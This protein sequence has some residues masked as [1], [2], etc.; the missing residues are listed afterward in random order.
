MADNTVR[1]RFVWH[2]LMTPNGTGAHEFY[3]KTVGWTTEPWKQ[4]PSYTMFA[5]PTGPLGASVETRTG[6]PE[7]IPYVGTPDVDATAEAVTRL[8]GK[9]ITPPT[10]LP[11]AGRYAVFADPQGATFGVHGS[12]GEPRPEGPTRYGEFH[13]HELATTV[14]AK[15][16]FAF[17]TEL[18]GWD[19]V[20]EYDMGPSGIYLLFGRN[21]EQKGGMFHKGNAGKPGSA[22]WVCYVRV[23]N[24]DD[25]VEKVKA[26]RGL[27][28]NG[29]MDVPGGDR[30]AQL[31]DPYGAFFAVHMTAADVKAAKGAKGIAK[32]PKP[33]AAKPAP[34]AKPAVKPTAAKPV[35]PAVATKAKKK[36]AKKAAAKKAKKVAKKAKK[37][38]KKTGKKAAKTKSGAK[39]VAKRVAKKAKRTPAKKP[40]KARRAKKKGRRR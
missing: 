26:A 13:W 11:N 21:G 9:T 19:A 1:G 4:N 31:T 27:L 23:P 29:P 30:I 34:V 18:F 37:P 40:A 36:V 17:Y 7:W 3:A 8:G 15:E 33:A 2:E 22:Y 20:S 16:A 38:A 28:L 32:A 10:D 35:K 25:V 5:A 12:S 39:K 24:V 6:T 14:P